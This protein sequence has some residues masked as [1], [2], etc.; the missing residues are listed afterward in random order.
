[1]NYTIENPRGSYK[2]FADNSDPYPLKGV[3]YPVDYGSIEG[4]TGEDGDPLDIFVG[5]GTI[6]GYLTV[7]RTDVPSETKIMYH[8]TEAEYQSI[9]TVFSPVVITADRLDTQALEE[10][11]SRYQNT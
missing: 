7:W 2:Q 10:L 8:V 11:L 1:M 4:Y 3:T 9:L 5:T 6:N